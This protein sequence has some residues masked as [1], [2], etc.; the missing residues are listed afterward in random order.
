MG[1]RE[2][3]VTEQPNQTGG[4]ATLEIGDP[5]STEDLNSIA[6]AQRENE[7]ISATFPSAGNP[8]LWIQQVCHVCFASRKCANCFNTSVFGGEALYPLH[9]FPALDSVVCI[10]VGFAIPR[11]SSAYHD[12][13]A[14]ILRGLGL[15]TYFRYSSWMD[16]YRGPFFPAM[17]CVSGRMTCSPCFAVPRA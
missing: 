11:T 4:T 3:Q 8:G 9:A 2:N 16:G 1:W 5:S 7:L 12:R 14:E 13:R 10:V 17:R 15:D 6:P